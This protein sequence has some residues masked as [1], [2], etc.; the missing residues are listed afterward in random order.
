ML[1]LYIAVVFDTELTNFYYWNWPRSMSSTLGN[2]SN[3]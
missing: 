3:L 1:I 2:C